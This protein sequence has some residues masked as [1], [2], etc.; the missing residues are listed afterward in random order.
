MIRRAVAASN[1]CYGDALD[2]SGAPDSPSDAVEKCSAP[3]RTS[4][5]R[6][7]LV[8]AL[9]ASFASRAKP[10]CT[11]LCEPLSMDQLADGGGGQQ[12]GTAERSREIMSWRPAVGDKRSALDA[13]DTDD[14]DA[15]LCRALRR[16]DCGS[17][18]QRGLSN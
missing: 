13:P 5:G 14:D 15:G 10:T 2:A 17:G 7:K 12:E 9:P 8:A 4:R 16:W 1:A 6:V 18:S 3:T 11:N